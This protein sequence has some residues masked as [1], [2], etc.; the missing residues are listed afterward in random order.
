MLLYVYIYLLISLSWRSLGI[1]EDEG[2]GTQTQGSNSGS[3]DA[4]IGPGT[5]FFYYER[6][7]DRGTR[8]CGELLDEAEL[9]RLNGGWEQQPTGLQPNELGKYAGERESIS[10]RSN[11]V[12]GD[13]SQGSHAV[14]ILLSI[15]DRIT[16]E[17]AGV[18]W[19]AREFSWLKLAGIW[20]W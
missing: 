5:G 9:T 13:K 20:L 18:L 10:P 4:C 11:G 3:L 17:L 2:N 7:E 19:R 1:L 15:V 12:D 6:L 8:E 14:R 16:A